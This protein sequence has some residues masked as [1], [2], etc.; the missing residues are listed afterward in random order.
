MSEK[1]TPFCPKLLDACH[2]RVVG[3][4]FYVDRGGERD[5][6]CRGSH[7][8]W[9]QPDAVDPTRGGCGLCPVAQRFVDPA[10]VA[11]MEEVE[12]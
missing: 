3:I 5:A 12:E 6:H 7:C 11:A 2:T 9:W 4:G 10:V 8:A 1:E